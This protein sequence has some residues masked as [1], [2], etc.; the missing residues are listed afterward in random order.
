M[1]SLIFIDKHKFF[2]QYGLVT[3]LWCSHDYLVINFF[4]LFIFISIINE[5][6]L[7]IYISSTCYGNV[8]YNDSFVLSGWELPY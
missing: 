6:F 8:T 2:L 3:L 5:R 4:F 7:V 1:S